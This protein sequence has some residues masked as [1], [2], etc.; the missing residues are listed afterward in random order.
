MASNRS[1]DGSRLESLLQRAVSEINAKIKGLESTVKDGRADTKAYFSLGQAYFSR[2][3]TTLE[4]GG[5]PFSA[6]LDLAPALANTE[7]SIALGSSE[8]ETFVQAVAICTAQ[9][10]VYY[11]I[12]GNMPPADAIF[13]KLTRYFD[14]SAETAIRK[15]KESSGKNHALVESIA[16]AVEPLISSKLYQNLPQPYG[17]SFAASCRTLGASLGM[18][19]ISGKSIDLLLSV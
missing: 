9:I 1:P 17:E 2:A 3:T 10:M 7:K 13:Q 11:R 5:D 6:S 18:M 19:T 4:N 14:C 8:P 15:L 12:R 16:S